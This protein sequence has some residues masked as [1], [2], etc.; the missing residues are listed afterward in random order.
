MVDYMGKGGEDAQPRLHRWSKL[1]AL[2]VSNHLTWSSHLSILLMK[3]RER[4]YSLVKLTKAKS[5]CEVP[6]NF[7]RGARES[8]LTALQTGTG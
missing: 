6:F 1:A 3:A 4:L 8:I 7:Y 2:S 5:S